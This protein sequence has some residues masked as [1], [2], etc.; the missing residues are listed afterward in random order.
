ML[1]LEVVKAAYNITA[2]GDQISLKPNHPMY[3]PNENMVQHILRLKRHKVNTFHLLNN[4][5]SYRQAI[6]VDI[7]TTT[8]RP[9]DGEIRLIVYWIKFR[10]L[11]P[12]IA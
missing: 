7:E 2:I 12:M 8:K 3:Q 6:A 4:E 10:N 11:H 5:V 1:P 9:E